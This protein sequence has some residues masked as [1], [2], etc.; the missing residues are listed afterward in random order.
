V[1][2]AKLQLVPPD[3]T[4]AKATIEV[5]EAGLSAF[6]AEGIELR[7]QQILALTPSQAQD[8]WI[9]TEEVNPVVLNGHPT[10]ELTASFI[11]AGQ[12]LKLSVLFVDLGNTHLRFT[13][14]CRGSEFEKLH[15]CFRSSI[16]SWQWQP[17]GLARHAA[18]R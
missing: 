12:R 18:V 6:D 11:Q 3:S 15:A 13:L 8:R 10:C 4:S 17:T 14:L 2:P 9:E 16:A 5:V 1:S 7:R